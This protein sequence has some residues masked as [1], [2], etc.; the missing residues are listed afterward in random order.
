[1]NSLEEMTARR[2][3]WLAEKPQM[4]GDSTVV[5]L[6]PGD[7]A[8][9]H[10][11]STGDDGQSFLKIYR[12]HQFPSIGSKG[13]RFNAYR[14]CPRTSSDPDIT[15][16]PNCDMGHTQIKERMS[17][18]FYIYYV[19]RATMPQIRDGQQ[20]L[21]QV[22]QD[23]KIYWHEEINGYR[24][25]EDSAWR[26]SP[27][28]MILQL[29]GAYKGLHNFVFQLTASGTGTQRRYAI[30]ALPNSQALTPE[31]YEGAKEACEPVIERLRKEITQP[32]QQNPQAQQQNPQTQQQAPSFV[33]PSPTGIFTAPQAQPPT[34]TSG[35]AAQASAAP[36]APQVDLQPIPEP[37]P[38]KPMTK[39]F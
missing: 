38:K 26:D 22:Q 32:A 33:A 28:G 36:Q 37:D 3:Q 35:A 39:L 16:C 2:D 20:Q 9:G 4:G 12:S 11:V 24:I 8:Y 5:K 7:I 1:M 18:W 13:G 27:L 23:G 34:F 6:G 30:F 19:L 21:N 17:F 15:E 25:W 31:L 29:K 10:F 14:Y